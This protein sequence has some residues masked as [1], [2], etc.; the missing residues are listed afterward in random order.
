MQ[1]SS[2]APAP[3]FDPARLAR[4][5]D[6]PGVQAQR[7]RTRE[8][9]G[10]RSGQLVLDL[11]CGPGHL[12]TE[13]AADL[14]ADGRVVAL[15][16]SPAM[17]EAT[18]SRAARQGVGGRCAL[19]AADATALPLADAACD[20]AVVV[21][22]LE[23]VPDVGGALAE[24]HRVL[25]PGGRAVLVDTDWRSCVWHTDDRDRTDRVLR[26]WEAHFVHPQLPASLVRLAREA[27]FGDVEVHAVPVVETETEQDTYSLGMAATIAR[28]V[29]RSEPE[30]ARAWR[31]DVRAQA[32]AG[33]YFFALT[34]FATVLTR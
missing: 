22:V 27:G 6:A 5:Y 30:Q 24:L 17:L 4:T 28:F 2:T 20:A 31:E 33:T 12:T 25:R 16:R 10:A 19:A 15:D 1:P 21:Q 18:R 3:A 14:G 9:L 26:A 23:Y 11:G 7:R 8:L 29:G 34:R 32:A 13:L